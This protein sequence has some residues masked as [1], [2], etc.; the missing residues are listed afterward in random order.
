MFPFPPICVIA[1]AM[2]KFLFDKEIYVISAV[3]EVLVKAITDGARVVQL[4]DKE[5]PEAVIRQKA[6]EL[7]SLKKFHQFVFIIND[8]P[9]LAASIGAD[10]VHIGQDFATVTARRIIGPGRILGKTT[11][12]LLQANQAY[13][14]GADYI[15]AGPVFAT[16]T[17]PGR[18]PV[19]LEY[20]REVAKAD[21]GIP[22]VAIGGLDIHNAQEVV[23]AGARTL[24]VVR[25]NNQ[26][27]ELLTI[28]QGYQ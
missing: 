1:P 23:K 14:D 19:G 22:F 5:A 12:N 2:K 21:I 8:Y 25:A 6:K 18:L 27:K 26:I 28:L 10:G 3:P 7:L 17:K 9:E 20:V 15:S 16:P 11:H 4:R 24:G 13:H